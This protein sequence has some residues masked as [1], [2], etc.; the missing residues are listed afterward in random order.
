[1]NK[2]K[3]AITK[4]PDKLWDKIRDIMPKEKPNNSIGH[5]IV[6]FRKVLNGILYVLR[7]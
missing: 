3:H 5:P 2:N 4:I 6:P 7:T 1:M